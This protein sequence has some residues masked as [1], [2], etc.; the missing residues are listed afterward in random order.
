MT[1]FVAI[2]FPERKSGG[3]QLPD[4]TGST[5]VA[6]AHQAAM[7]SI[8][9]A[10]APE[11]PATVSGHLFN[12]ATHHHLQSP[13]R[14]TCRDVDVATNR[15]AIGVGARGLDDASAFVHQLSTHHFT[16][17]GDRVDHTNGDIREGFFDGGGQLSPVGLTERAVRLPSM[18]TLLVVVEPQSVARITLI[19]FGSMV[20][21]CSLARPAVQRQSL[22]CGR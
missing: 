2:G 10:T 21:R 19:E 1:F 12:D 13:T 20:M 7:V 9:M 5:R 14:G 22:R 3:R 16:N 8:T 6:S 11:R 15:I 18:N 17:F 4:A